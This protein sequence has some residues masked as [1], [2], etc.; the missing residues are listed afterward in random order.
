MLCW[1]ILASFTAG[2]YYYQ[3][4]NLNARVQ[5]TFITVNL[6]IDY[7]NNTRFWFNNTQA[8]GGMSLFDITRHIM[9]VTYSANP[10]FGVSV[11]SINGLKNSFSRYWIWWKMGDTGWS[12]G[13]VGVDS[14]VVTNGE[15]LLWYYEDI[16]TWPPLKPK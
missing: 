13:E 12:M 1:A 2:Y 5:R 4:N 8:L 9:N 7:G 16:T 6:G 15:I 11:E 3:Y 10:T 14:Y